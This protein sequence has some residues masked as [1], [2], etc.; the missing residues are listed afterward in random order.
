M[1][2][3][4][5]GGYGSSG[6]TAEYSNFSIKDS[7][8]RPNTILES[9]LRLKRREW[10]T[11]CLILNMPSP[12]TYSDRVDYDSIRESMQACC[13]TEIISITRRGLNKFHKLWSKCL[14]NKIIEL[15]GGT[16]KESWLAGSKCIW[17]VLDKANLD[18]VY[19]LRSVLQFMNKLE[20]P[21]SLL[22][23][24]L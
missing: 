21:S 23:N 14:N 3:P 17:A 2:G 10:S 1:N 5:L 15:K 22:T 11:Y 12:S 19:K 18:K 6:A 13:S 20:Q 7:L 16:A 8:N 24:F 9:H 4:N